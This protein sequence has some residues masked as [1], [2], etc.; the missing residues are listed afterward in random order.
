MN[1]SIADHYRSLLQAHGDSHE[2]AQ[3]S[4]RESQE[5]RYAVLAEVG[6][7]QGARVLDF[8]CG[9]GHLATWLQGRGIDC[10]YTGVDIVTEFFPHAR[11]KHPGHRFGTLADFEGE[12]FDYVLVSGVFN[13]RMDDNA[14]FLARTLE[15]LFAR[16]DR[17]LAFNLMSAYV[18][19]QDP[20][21]WYA[22]PEDVFGLVKKLTPFVSLRNDYVVKQVAVPFEFA[23]YAYRQPREVLR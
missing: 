8:G 2:A 14:A 12:R 1:E 16:T 19:Y 22:R 11:A 7:L 18:D 3:Y 15:D 4:S 13:N 6:D 9:T 17:A 10:R 20:G 23:V 5:A 21:L